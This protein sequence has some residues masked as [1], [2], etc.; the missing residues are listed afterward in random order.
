M[1]VEGWGMCARVRVCQ[2]WAGGWEEGRRESGRL[3]QPHAPPPHPSLAPACSF[4]AASAPARPRHPT[5]TLQVFSVAR[6]VLSLVAGDAIDIYL[7]GMLRRLREEASVAAAIRSLQ[8]VLWPGGVWCQYAAARSRSTS[9]SSG[10]GSG[11]GTLRASRA[12][13]AAEEG[14][15]ATAPCAASM[16]ADDYMLPRCATWRQ[17]LAGP[18]APAG[19]CAPCP[20]PLEACWS[21]GGW[22]STSLLCQ[23]LP[24][25]APLC[26]ALH[27]FAPLCPAFPADP[28][29]AY[30]PACVPPCFDASRRHAVR[31]ALRCAMLQ[32]PPA[33]GCGGGASGC[34]RHDA[35]PPPLPALPRAPG[36]QGGVRR[37][38]VPCRGAKRA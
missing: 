10:S 31:A 19:F 7:L 15:G 23:A 27:P 9:S 13:V 14:S 32:W 3:P 30:L 24:R 37:V 4:S 11:G 25:L 22:P 29:A 38:G 35:V 2:G 12:A 20:L 33:S 21:G 36:G 17:A 26:P 16:Q 5:P 6:Q 1:R 8:N 34:L 28:H 18:G